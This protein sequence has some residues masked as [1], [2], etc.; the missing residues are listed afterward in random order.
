M[1][2]LITDLLAY[3]RVGTQAK[4]LKPIDCRVAF[5]RAISN[6]QLA[7]DE[8]SAIVTRTALPTVTAD[9]SQLVE[10][11][12]NLI[13]NAIKFHGKKPSEIHVDAEQKKKH[14]LFSVRDNGIG[15][16][17][18]Y[19]DRIFLIF[20]RLHNRK[21]YPGTG[22]GLTVCKKIVERHGGRI[23]VES[24]PGKGTTFFFTLPA[25]GDK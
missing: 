1:Q 7:I 17:P 23:W 9:E 12:Q 22:I 20:Q 6:L 8:S 15:I 11:F 4:P 18:Q 16:D 14:W 13:S 19:F 2:A 24:E 10:L 3:S 5:D 25:I 21:E